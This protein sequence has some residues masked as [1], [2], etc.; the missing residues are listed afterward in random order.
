MSRPRKSGARISIDVGGVC[1]RT[2]S[3]QATSARRRLAQIV[4]IDRCNHHEFELHRG[5]RARDSPGSC[6]SSGF[7]RPWAT[8]QNGQRRVHSRPMIMKVAVPWAKHSPIFGHEA[9]SHTVFNRCER[10]S[11]LRRP[12]CG[13]V[14][15][16]A[17]IH[18]GFLSGSLRSI[19]IGM[20]AVF[21]AP[22]PSRTASASGVEPEW[23][24]CWIHRRYRAVSILQPPVPVRTGARRH[25]R[26]RCRVANRPVGSRASG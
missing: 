24:I 23:D 2:A 8:S 1:W 18:A 22:F 5:E 26:C 10:N 13:C 21:A 15:E 25:P 3:M 17:R 7:G 19:L 14:G 9:S 4:A 6:G 20:R 12:T 11:A 16:R